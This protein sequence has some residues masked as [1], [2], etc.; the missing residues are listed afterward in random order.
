MDG[1]KRDAPAL[2]SSSVR[3][4]A[5]PAGRVV[6]RK[7]DALRSAIGLQVVNEGSLT[8]KGETVSSSFLS[9]LPWNYSSAHHH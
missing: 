5:N 7:A 2:F 1:A 6:Y 4:A 9:N 8:Y 3:F